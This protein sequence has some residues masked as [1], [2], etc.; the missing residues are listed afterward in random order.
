MCIGII[1][2]MVIA[3]N[4]PRNCSFSPRLLLDVL[5]A[6]I[7]LSTARVISSTHRKNVYRHV[8]E[9]TPVFAACFC[10]SRNT[11]TKLSYCSSRSTH[12][13]CIASHEPRLLFPRREIGSVSGP[14]HAAFGQRRDGQQGIDAKAGWHSGAIPTGEAWVQIGVVGGAR[15]KYLPAV[16]HH[17]TITVSN[18]CEWYCN[19][20][21]NSSNSSL[22]GSIRVRIQSSICSLLRNNRVSYTAHAKL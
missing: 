12:R 10:R 22:A 19:S 4:F 3:P 13:M 9:Y 2:R 18:T 5:V 8:L 11:A 14:A 6:L 17:A 16:V 15:V 21:S 20:N 7:V 1:C